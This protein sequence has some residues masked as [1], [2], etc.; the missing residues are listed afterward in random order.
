MENTEQI[1]RAMRMLTNDPI[2]PLYNYACIECMFRFSH[3]SFLSTV[4][5]LDP[6]LGWHSLQSYQFV[7]TDL[8]CADDPTELMCRRNIDGIKCCGNFLVNHPP[9]R[10]RHKEGQCMGSGFNCFDAKEDA[11][12]EESKS[13]ESTR[14]E[15]GENEDTTDGPGQKGTTDRVKLKHNSH[16]TRVKSRV[17]LP[18]NPAEGSM[19][20]APAAAGEGGLKRIWIEHE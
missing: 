4:A 16:G 19:K 6:S 7:S 9:Q 17:V 14:R 1:I 5:L 15:N 10:P 20:P 18:K 13:D 11:K 3:P 8:F 2:N 12:Q